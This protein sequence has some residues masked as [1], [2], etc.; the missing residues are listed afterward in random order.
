LKE[1]SDCIFFNFGPD[2]NDVS[3]DEEEQLSDSSIEK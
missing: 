2:C 1:K 3:E